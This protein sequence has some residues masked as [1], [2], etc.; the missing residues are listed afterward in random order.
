MIPVAGEGSG[1]RFARRWRRWASEGSVLLLLEGGPRSPGR[2]SPPVSRPD[3]DLHR[4]LILGGGRPATEGS[5][6]GTRW[7]VR[8]E[9]RRCA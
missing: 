2:R 8:P 1:A 6:P 3:R 5:G 7:K 9:S 4:A